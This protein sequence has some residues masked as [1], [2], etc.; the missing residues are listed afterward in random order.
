MRVTGLGSWRGRVLVLSAVVVLAGA[1]GVA[2]L[3]ASAT[4]E[5]EGEA[6]TDDP[7]VGPDY[8]AASAAVCTLLDPGDLELALGA[9]YEEGLDPGGATF[10]FAEIPAVTTCFY[11]PATEGYGSVEV[12]VV[13]AYAE[14]VL[15]EHRQRLGDRAVDIDGVGEEAVWD[16]EGR[17]LLVLAEEKI[18]GVSVP[19]T[20]SWRE[21]DLIERARRLAEA[22]IGRLR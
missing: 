19:A 21:G 2:M 11:P 3:V 16:R 7:L 15:H 10:A 5:G 18:V 14:Q 1:I 8:Y 9:A 13:Y 6:D 20:A 12:G 22:A 4:G 17:E